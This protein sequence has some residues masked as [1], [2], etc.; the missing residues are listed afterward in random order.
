MSW[1]KRIRSIVHRSELEHNLNDELQLHIELKTQENIEAGMSPE[2]ARY[3]ALK[4]F[5]RI[6][7]KKEQCRDADRLR[8]IED[9][10]QDFRFGLRQL[11]HNPGFT[12]VAVITLALGIGANA[13]IFS[14]VDAVLLNPLPYRRSSQLVMVWEEDLA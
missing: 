14:V 10:I 3:A 7:Q 2:E 8:F 5:G 12:A 11:H 13:A 9:L 6:E 4:A 1:I